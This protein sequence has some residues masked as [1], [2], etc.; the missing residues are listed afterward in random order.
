MVGIPRDAGLSLEKPDGRLAKVVLASE[1]AV[2]AF[3]DAIVRDMTVQIA[4]G[5]LNADRAF[6]VQEITTQCRSWPDTA[7][8]SP[9]RLYVATGKIMRHM[10]GH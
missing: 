7:R 3:K 9:S 4:A 8:T 10:E 2:E 5:R 1:D 6:L